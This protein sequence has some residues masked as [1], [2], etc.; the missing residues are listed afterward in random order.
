MIQS[1]KNIK[2]SEFKNISKSYS[3]VL[4]RMVE[5]NIFE[6]YELEEKRNPTN[7]NLSFSGNTTLN[8]NAGDYVELWSYTQFSSGTN[9]IKANNT[10]FQGYKI[11]T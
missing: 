3:A 4:K 5:K 11:I 2:A 7:H 6:F 10:V 9:T 8:L 1:F